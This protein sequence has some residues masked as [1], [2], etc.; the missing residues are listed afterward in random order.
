[1]ALT[2]TVA[3]GSSMAEAVDEAARAMTEVELREALAITELDLEFVKEN[4]AD[5]AL[6]IDDRGWAPLDALGGRH[7]LTRGALD[8][9]SMRDRTLVIANPLIRRG[10]NLRIAYVWGQGVTIGAKATGED[11]DE[12]DVNAVVQAWLDDPDVRKVLTSSAAR[13]RNERAVATDGNLFVALFTDTRRTGSVSPRVVPFVQVQEVVNNPEDATDVWYYRRDIPNGTG[14]TTTVYHPDVNHRP[15]VR[16]QRLTRKATVRG[17]DV[18]GSGPALGLNL[19]KDGDVM[20]DAPVIHLKVNDLPEWDFGVG[21]VF[22]AAP[23]AKAY[24][25]FLEDWAKLVKALSRF[26]WRRSGGKSKA[27]AAA[28]SARVRQRPTTD[29]TDPRV[30]AALGENPRPVGQFYNDLDGVLEAIPKTGATIDSESGRPL[31]A[32]VS[33]GLDVPV[34]M[35]LTDPGVSGNRAT[36]ETLDTPTENMANGRRAVWGDWYRVLLDYVIDQAVK[37]PQGPLSGSVTRDAWGREVVTLDGDTSR[38]LVIDW[39]DLTDTPVDVLLKAIASADAMEVLPPLLV[40]RLA[41]TAF[42]VRDADEWL[43][44]VT[45]PET[46]DFLPPMD[47]VDAARNRRAKAG[48]GD[49]EPPP[50]E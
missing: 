49:P 3:L 32:M 15:L 23:W 42:N 29:A 18:P 39:P 43:K 7:Q 41:L 13:E 46:G 40:V 48:A 21:D 25:E 1:M 5:L 20:W 38:S 11:G 47:A 17:Q 44:Q 10:V 14:D 50:A 6:S 35:L 37:A 9:A 26:A 12:Q 27:A 16:P 2:D 8:S 24:K 36:A 28:A 4:L 33:A 45:D 30:Q 19:E 31:A 34:T 22:A